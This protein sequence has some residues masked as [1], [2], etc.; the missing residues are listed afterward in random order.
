MKL[1]DVRDECSSFLVVDPVI[2]PVS[3]AVLPT[4]RFAVVG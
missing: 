2:R 1:S 3:V 4:V